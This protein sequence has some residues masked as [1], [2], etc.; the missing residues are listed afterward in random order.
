MNL[1][2]PILP[3]CWVGQQKTI[4]RVNILQLAPPCSSFFSCIFATLWLCSSQNNYC[5]SSLHDFPKT[6]HDGKIPIIGCQPLFW[7][8]HISCLRCF[9]F[10]MW[11]TPLVDIHGLSFVELS[12]PL[13]FCFI[14]YTSMIQLFIGQQC[15]MTIFHLSI[16]KNKSLCQHMSAPFFMVKSDMAPLFIRYPLVNQHGYLKIYIYRRW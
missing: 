11:S 10:N 15:E 2:L 1:N 9:S 7:W 14:L 8:S 13:F 16:P 3:H 12:T 4:R 6:S 5:T